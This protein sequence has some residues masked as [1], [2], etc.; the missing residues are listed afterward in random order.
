MQKDEES[1]T[2]SGTLLLLTQPAITRSKLTIETLEKG[3]NY[4]QS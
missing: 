3:G 4:V 1:M 2:L